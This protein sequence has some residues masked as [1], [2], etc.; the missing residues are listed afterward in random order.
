MTRVYLPLNRSGL[1]TAL[2]AG[3]IGPGPLTVYTVTAELRAEYGADAVVE[4]LE[5]AAYGRAAAA[6]RELLDLDRPD[7][8]RRI[9]VAADVETVRARSDGGPGEATVPGPVPWSAVASVHADT[10]DLGA[11]RDAD[12]EL[13]WYATQEAADLLR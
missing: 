3:E 4:E 8:R 6:S 2:R 10:D 1:A 5:Y 7:D 12:L 11:D 13:A 9:V